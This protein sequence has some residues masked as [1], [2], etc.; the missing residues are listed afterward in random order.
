MTGPLHTT[1][2]REASSPRHSYWMP[3]T[4]LCFVQNLD[5]TVSANLTYAPDR[6]I[7]TPGAATPVAARFPV[8]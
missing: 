2:D 8:R 7:E 1:P 5:A 3:T 6:S 4:Q